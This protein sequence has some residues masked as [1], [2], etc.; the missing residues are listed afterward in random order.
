MLRL[1]QK[2]HHP[3]DR[4][5]VARYLLARGCRTDILMVAAL[6]DADLVWRHLDADRECIR[7]NVSEEC[8]PKQF[9][10]GLAPWWIS[11]GR[12]EAP[13]SG[14]PLF[15]LW[16]ETLLALWDC[17]LGGFFRPIR[18]EGSGHTGTGLSNPSFGRYRT[19]SLCSK[20]YVH[21]RG[22]RDPGSGFDLWK[23]A[24]C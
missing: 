19:I 22:E 14:C 5:D 13:F 18:D 24:A 15:V 23:C 16:G 11:R 21:C 2:R 9:V 7:M 20:S 8:F 17:G 6:G 3:R 1:E 10:A 12:L 4:Q